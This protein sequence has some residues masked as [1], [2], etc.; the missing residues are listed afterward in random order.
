MKAIRVI[1][2]LSCVA[3]LISGCGE[4][5]V[6]HVIKISGLDTVIIDANENQ[7]KPKTRLDIFGPSNEITTADGS[8]AEVFVGRII[9]TQTAPSYSSGILTRK[10]DGSAG[11]PPISAI[12]KGMICRKTLGKTL[13][14]EKK[15]YKY[16]KK[17]LKRQ[18]KLTKIKAK[19]ETYKALDTVVQDTNDIDTINTSVSHQTIDRKGN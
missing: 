7:I 11:L 15:I 8:K 2:L 19:R 5:A 18:Y 12:H 13:R 1:L 4:P 16:N 6:Y 9:I 10:L 17:A 14:A 3:F